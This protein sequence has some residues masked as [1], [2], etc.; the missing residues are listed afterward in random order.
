MR[1]ALDKVKGK[2][3]AAAN[4]LKDLNR[5]TFVFDSPAVLALGFHLLHKKVQSL[6][7]TL[8]RVS[9]FF[10]AD[11]ALETTFKS[12]PCIHLNVKINGWI[13]EIMLTLADVASVKE[14]LHKYYE[15]ARAEEVAELLHPIF[16]P[17]AG[18]AGVPP[19]AIH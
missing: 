2:N 3:G 19:V 8:E 10:F 11:G 12:P 17:E 16:T 1:A 5:C 6:D 9:N 14:V 4:T 13:Y 7:G 15:V 18:D